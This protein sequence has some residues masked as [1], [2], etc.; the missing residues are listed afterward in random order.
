MPES[1]QSLVIELPALRR[2]A[3]NL[4]KGHA[5]ADDL[6]QSTL[7]R[8]IEKFHLYEPDTDLRSWLFAVMRNI[9]RDHLRKHKKLDAMSVELTEACAPS[10]QPDQIVNLIGKDLMHH[11]GT[12][13]PKYQKLL[14]LV[15]DHSISYKEAAEATGIPLGTVRSRLFRARI[16]LLKK[17]DGEIPAP[18]APKT[19]SVTRKVRK[20]RRAAAAM[21]N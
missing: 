13:K 9:F 16:Q 6:V 14:L 11:F 15:A 18:R 20:S 2:Y 1:T 19:P 4:M 3:M 5:N 8:A 17:L 12:L 7:E 21:S 10:I